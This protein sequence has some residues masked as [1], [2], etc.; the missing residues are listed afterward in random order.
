MTSP[1]VRTL[2]PA[3]RELLGPE[4]ALRLRTWDGGE[5]G[6]AYAPAVVLNNPGALRRLLWA[7]GELGLARAYVTGDLDFEGDLADGLRRLRR[8]A[9]RAP[10]RR[11]AAIL[12]ALVRTPGVVGSRPPVPGA[13]A[14]LRGRPHSRRRAR[15]AI[16]HHYDLSNAFYEL[17]LDES[18]AYSCAYYGP[19]D[20]LA[21]AQRRKLDLICAKL[22][23]RSGMRILDVGCGWGSL[24]LH[25]ARSYGVAATG[26]T[27]SREQQAHVRERAA[28]LDVTV[29]LQ[30]Y[31]DV[32]D[33]PYDA[34]AS[35]EMGE[36]VGRDDYPA[37]ASAL[38]RLVRPGGRVL[39]QQ[40][41]R[42]ARHP[43]GGPFI[44]R[45]V[46]PDMHMRP[47]GE[48]IALLEASGLVFEHAESMG[49]HYVRTVQAWQQ[50]F[51]S[52]Y[53]RAL[54]L[55]GAQTARV[56]RLYLAGGALAFEEG[57]MDVHQILLRRP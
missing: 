29:R 21:G 1:V 39:V 26:V 42:G 6:P 3:L 53:S 30:D 27:L 51:D 7:P 49:D 11:T 55:V 31:R 13:E 37:Y 20:D 36:H 33:P 24:P 23:M 9:L 45:Y 40:M 16:S 46:A 34:V 4:P 8:T 41:S 43:G 57:R 25:A 28:G 44:E 38:H 12:R 5:Y 17:I 14:R 22:G 50:A 56:W 15:A 47:I 19:G 54:A 52:H 2:A 10:R 48:T 18:M 35:I 32:H